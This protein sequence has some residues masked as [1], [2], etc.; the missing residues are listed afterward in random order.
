MG[1]S[2]CYFPGIRIPKHDWEK[3]LTSL[4][5]AVSVT[6]R[7][8]SFAPKAFREA[9][10]RLK[11]TLQST[12]SDNFGSGNMGS[13]RSIANSSGA[14]QMEDAVCV[15]DA[16]PTLVLF[17]SMQS[18]L[19]AAVTE[20]KIDRRSRRV[21]SASKINRKSPGV[22]S[23]VPAIEVPILSSTPVINRK[24]P[25]VPS[26]DP[27]SEVPIPSSTPVINRKSP[28]VPSAVPEIEVPIPSSTSAINRKSPGVA[29]DSNFS[30]SIT[31]SSCVVCSSTSTYRGT[32]TTSM[33][34]SSEHSLAAAAT[35]K[36]S[37]V[38]A[39]APAIT[40]HS[41]GEATASVMSKPGSCVSTGSGHFA[42]TADSRPPTRGSPPSVQCKSPQT[43]VSS[44]TVPS[45]IV[46]I[47]F[48]DIF[49]VTLIS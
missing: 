47:K 34:S 33:I 40:E 8:T 2:P 13:S 49:R 29:T 5:K 25:G 43:E 39:P 46:S 41:L 4:R 10:K 31:F 24:S 30:S 21:S 6:D 16:S 3:E 12:N 19:A 35:S 26:A 17:R 15:G 14:D 36:Q 38:V 7:R 45:Q 22:P 9:S 37:Q 32:S 18:Q 48:P 23:A 44:V 20:P 11:S 28:G 27:A 42:G 1:R